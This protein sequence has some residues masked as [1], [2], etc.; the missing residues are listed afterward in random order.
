MRLDISHWAPLRQ[1]KGLR[2]RTWSRARG[3]DVDLQFLISCCLYS[4]LKLNSVKVPEYTCDKNGNF[5]SAPRGENFSKLVRR[6]FSTP[7]VSGSA[8]W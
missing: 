6:E 1:F 5:V 3:R 2:T 8:T 4:G 7:P